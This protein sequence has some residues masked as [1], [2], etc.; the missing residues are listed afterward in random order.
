MSNVILDD[1]SCLS[2]KYGYWLISFRIDYIL[3]L[4][5]NLDS[6]GYIS[7]ILLI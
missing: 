1:I 2:I 3:Y 4:Y 5:L 7:I 6:I